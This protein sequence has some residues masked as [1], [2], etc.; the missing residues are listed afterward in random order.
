MLRSFM[1]MLD[2]RSAGI[3]MFQERLGKAVVSVVTS[4]EVFKGGLRG[5]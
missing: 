1:G 3:A 4:K 5:R 2:M